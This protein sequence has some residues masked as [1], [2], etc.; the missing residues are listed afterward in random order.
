VDKANGKH[1]KL[2]EIMMTWWLAPPFPQGDE[3]LIPIV[4]KLNKCKWGERWARVKGK[5]KSL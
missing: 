4:V 3:S 2:F 5:C 1:F